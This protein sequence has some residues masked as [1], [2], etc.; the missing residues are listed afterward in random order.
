[1]D[2]HSGGF[3]LKFP[4]HDNELAQAEV[5]SSEENKCWCSM[6]MKCTKW[7]NEQCE[8]KYTHNLTSTHTLSYN[9]HKTSKPNLIH[10]KTVD[11][12]PEIVY[13]SN[14]KKNIFFDL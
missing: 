4:H 11:V 1:M 13:M 10:L 9:A 12:Q 7:H 8:K 14:L 2:I 3:D 6:E 5:S